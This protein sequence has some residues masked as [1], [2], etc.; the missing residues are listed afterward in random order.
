MR[1]HTG[2]ALKSAGAVVIIEFVEVVGEHIT[3]ELMLDG[4]GDKR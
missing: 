4:A 2:T 1:T 3:L